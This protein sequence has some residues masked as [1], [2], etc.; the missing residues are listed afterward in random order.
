MP[1]ALRH[2][3]GEDSDHQHADKNVSRHREWKTPPGTCAGCRAA[4][5]KICDY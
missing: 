5:E 3:A 4:S 2:I 1:P